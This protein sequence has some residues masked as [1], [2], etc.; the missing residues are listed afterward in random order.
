[1]LDIVNA[2]SCSNDPAGLTGQRLSTGRA[3]KRWPVYIYNLESNERNSSHSNR[4]IT[5]L[6]STLVNTQSTA[7]R[8]TSTALVVRFAS[9]EQIIT[10][11]SFLTN[12]LFSFSFSNVVLQVFQSL[13]S[14]CTISLYIPG[15]QSIQNEFQYIEFAF[16]WFFIL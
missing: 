2:F 10:F 12:Y 6:F 8:C 4:L 3:E 11:L 14:T 1:M 7:S 16:N 15:L 5:I 9:I 13:R